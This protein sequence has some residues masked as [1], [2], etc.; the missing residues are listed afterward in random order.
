MA[1]PLCVHYVC[2]RDPQEATDSRLLRAAIVN[3][4]EEACLPGVLEEEKRKLLAFVVSR[5]CFCFCFACFCFS[6]GKMPPLRISISNRRLGLTFYSR[7]SYTHII[8]ELQRRIDL[9]VHVDVRFR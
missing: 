7:T 1:S 6:I 5:F 3:V 9:V 2:A 8:L 4:L